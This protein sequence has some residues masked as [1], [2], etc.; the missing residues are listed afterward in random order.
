MTI[1]EMLARNARIYPDESALIE[2]KP[3]QK[4]RREITW[5]VFD[6]RANRVANALA[7]RGVG[8]GDKVLHLMLNSINWLEAYFGIIRT[9]AWAVPLNFRFTSGDIKYC[10]DIAEA[11]VMILGQEFAERVEAI[12]PQL[13]TIKDYIFVG[14]NT[15]QDMES[16]EDVID[17]ASPQPLKVDADRRGRV[18][19]L[20]YLGHYRRPQADT[21]HPQEHGVRRHHRS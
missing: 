18:R 17:K 13:P 20:L 4:I 19:A 14:E 8:K 5:R 21:A 6:E 16:F 9:G 15:P 10:A 3:S 2:L 11:K 12:R 7:A 1:A